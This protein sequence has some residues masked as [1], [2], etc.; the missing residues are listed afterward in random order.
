MRGLVSARSYAARPCSPG[1]SSI[2]RRR[3]IVLC[4]SVWIAK[5]VEGMAESQRCGQAWFGFRTNPPKVDS[6]FLDKGKRRNYHHEFPAP[7]EGCGNRRKPFERGGL[8]GCGESGT[9]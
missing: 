1:R 3:Q 4:A 7:P 2:G 6:R 8:S 5:S 9:Y